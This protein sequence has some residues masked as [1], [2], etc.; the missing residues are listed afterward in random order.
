[1]FSFNLNYFKP[2]H[3]IVLKL[4]CFFF[5]I[6]W[7]VW[8]LPHTTAVR[9]ICLAGGALLGVYQIY[10][11]RS[12]F[13][14]KNSWIPL[15]T[16]GLFFIWIHIHLFYFSSNWNLQ[17]NEYISIWKSAALS[18][19]FGLGLTFSL[20]RYSS[21]PV[22]TW[23]LGGL[24]V[25]MVIYFVKWFASTLISHNFYAPEYLLLF[26]G[27]ASYY[28]P[29]ISYVFF[30]MPIFAIF[31]S[32]IYRSTQATNTNTVNNRH[33]RYV[34]ASLILGLMSI[35]LIFILENTKNGIVYSSLLVLFFCIKFFS[36]YRNL[37]LKSFKVIALILL[38]TIAMVLTNIGQNRSWQNFFSDIKV[39][40]QADQY[41]NW[42]DGKNPLPVNEK[43]ESVSGTNYDRVHWAIVGIRLVSENPL[44]YGLVDRSFRHLAQKVWPESSLA[45]S[46]SGWL[47][48]TLGV[49]IPG[50]LLVLLS[51][52]FGLRESRNVSEPW[53]TINWA[54][55]IG[56]I[57]LFSTTEVSQNIYIAGIFL[58]MGAAIGFGAGNIKSEFDVP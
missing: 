10:R 53:K 11:S 41:S 38:I 15:L 2:T 31:L 49:G 23:L 16:V 51:F 30:L 32:L 35:Y 39:A 45:Q 57:L 1:M 9:N 42:Y 19:I 47:D 17:L 4:Q 28:V 14:L 44:G 50:A 27:A 25:S 56:V 52:F 18:F 58:I 46:H 13:S 40:V 7:L 34:A 37:S 54:I 29:K 55:V 6:L 24:S 48:F 21:E 33:R 3:L 5:V 22:N 8:P 20:I 12:D 26:K 36:N 43:G